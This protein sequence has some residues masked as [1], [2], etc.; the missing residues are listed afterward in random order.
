MKGYYG[1][2]EGTQSVIKVAV[3]IQGILQLLMMKGYIYVIG[4]TKNIIKSG[5]DIVSP[6]IKLK[7]SSVLLMESWCVVLGCR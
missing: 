5:V 7:N 2:P 4:E 6:P 3:S 1:D